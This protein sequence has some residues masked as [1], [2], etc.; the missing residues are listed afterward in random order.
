MRTQSLE[1]RFWHVD[2]DQELL[3]S[4]Y[5]LS[6]S[7]NP[8]T[9]RIPRHMRNIYTNLLNQ[10]QS[11]PL[12]SPFWWRRRIHFKWSVHAAAFDESLGIRKVSI[13]GQAAG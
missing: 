5:G 10:I 12:F 9:P 8:F 2:H 6:F 7:P 11:L 3:H 13:L 1:R 4:H